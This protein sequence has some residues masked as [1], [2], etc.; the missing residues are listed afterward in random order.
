MQVINLIS[1]PSASIFLLLKNLKL[2]I[3]RSHVVYSWKLGT[4]KTSAGLV[5]PQKKR[6]PARFVLRKGCPGTR[7]PDRQ[8]FPFEGAFF[9]LGRP[10]GH[11]ERTR[12][13]LPSAA[14]LT[15]YSKPR[16]GTDAQVTSICHACF[17]VFWQL[18][19]PVDCMRLPFK[20]DNLSGAT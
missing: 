17:E 6:M 9:P 13:V 11:S 19:V 1:K 2:C 18:N 5:I 20:D 12:H 4:Q 8:E 7:Q 15:S 14:N 10:S 16:F 3:E